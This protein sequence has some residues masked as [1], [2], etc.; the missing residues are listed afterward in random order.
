MPNLKQCCRPLAKGLATND[1]VSTA[2][3]ATGPTCTKLKQCLPTATALDKPTA[4][5]AP[6]CFRLAVKHFIHRHVAA[7]G[8]TPINTVTICIISILNDQWQYN[9]S[10]GDSRT[11]SRGEP[12]DRPLREVILW[13]GII[14][15]MYESHSR[16]LNITDSFVCL[17]THPFSEE[18][19]GIFMS[20]SVSNLN[21]QFL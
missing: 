9:S 11:P 4:H 8:G 13:C 20:R 14:K 6:S 3:G 21:A 2:N 17:C 18:V 12:P 5:N 10:N 7:T 15:V 16:R 19:E 1:A